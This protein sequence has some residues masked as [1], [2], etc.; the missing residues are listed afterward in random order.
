[1]AC[2]NATGAVLSSTPYLIAVNG[3]RCGADGSG[4]SFNFEQVEDQAIRL[5]VA[6]EGGATATYAGPTGQVAVVTTGSTPLD[7]ATVYSGPADFN[8]TVPQ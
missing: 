4:L 8:L 1:M 5:E 2:S 7:T 6:Q 3:G